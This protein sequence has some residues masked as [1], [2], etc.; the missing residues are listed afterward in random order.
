M[1]TEPHLQSTLTKMQLRQGAQLTSLGD[2]SLIDHFGDPAAE[3]AAVT[4]A[5]GAID[6]SHLGRI[7]VR[8]DGA[9]PL[10]ERAC[11]ADVARQEDDTAMLTCL[12]DAS[13]K[14]IDLA[15]LVRLE[16]MWVLSTNCLARPAVLAHLMQLNEAEGL[17]A[18]IDDQTFK[19]VL[20]GVAGPAAR[21][22][23]DG[24]LPGD[25]VSGLARGEARMGTMM[26]AR[27][28]AMRTGSTGTWSLEVMV[29]N[30]LAGPAWDFITKKAGHGE[31]ALPPI[32][33]VA[34][35]T[36]RQTAGIPAGQALTGQDPRGVNLTHLLNLADPDHH[37]LGREAL[38]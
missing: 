30:M 38:E 36:L 9:L 26:V 29:P 21:E 7:R 14:I 23:L 10:L 37:F 34:W 4:S 8:G 24:L 19:T 18:K 15:Y 25:K 32:G 6:L 33:Q 16:N 17:E 31:K 1:P 2:W 27:Y 20:I 22:L 13:G 11:T 28:I 35:N 3:V 12:C 5:A